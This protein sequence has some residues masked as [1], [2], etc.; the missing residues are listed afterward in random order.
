MAYEAAQASYTAELQQR[1]AL[2]SSQQLLFRQ[3]MFTVYD[4]ACQQLERDHAALL[5]ADRENS[6]VLNNRQ[7]VCHTSICGCTWQQTCLCAHPVIASDKSASCA[8]RVVT[9]A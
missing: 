5:A 3:I 1:F 4:S 2:A 7:A 6:R 9:Y 8:S